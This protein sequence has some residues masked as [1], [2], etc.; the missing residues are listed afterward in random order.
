[1]NSLEHLRTW[2]LVRLPPG[3]K[4]VKTN[5]VFDAKRDGE[6]DLVGCQ[7]RRVPKMFTKVEGIDFQ[8]IYAPVARYTTILLVLSLLVTLKHVPRVLDVKNAFFNR[9]SRKPFMRVNR[10]GLCVMESSIG[11]IS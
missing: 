1:M 5:W 4:V 8:E 11:F 6:G 3:L 7:A 2:E 9:L 10:T